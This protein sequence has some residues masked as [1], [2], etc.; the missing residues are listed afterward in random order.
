MYVCAQ[1]CTTLCNPMDYRPPG[2]SVPGM[3][4]QEYWSG[5]PFPTPGDFPHPG[6]KPTSLV[7]PGL[8]VRFFTT[9]ATWENT[10]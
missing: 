10:E 4:Q 6:I 9:S 2:S 3:F 1:S 5:L 7:S 8:A